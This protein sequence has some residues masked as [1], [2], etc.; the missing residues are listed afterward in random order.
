[1]ARA[2]VALTVAALL[3]LPAVL[4]LHGGESGASPDPRDAAA[5]RICL[6]HGGVGRMLSDRV[7]CADGAPHGWDG[8]HP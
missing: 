8:S 5:T 3:I 7:I 6:D 1:V 2:A 4:A